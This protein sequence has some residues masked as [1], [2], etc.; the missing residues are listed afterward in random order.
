MQK[1][2]QN[3]KPAFRAIL[4]IFG[5]NSPPGPEAMD[6]AWSGKRRTRTTSTPARKNVYAEIPMPG[7]IFLGIKVRPVPAEAPE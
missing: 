7:E 6:P 3:G 5:N 4:N 2:P 1:Y